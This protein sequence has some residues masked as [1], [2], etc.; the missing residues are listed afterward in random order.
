MKQATYLQ[1][2][3]AENGDKEAVSITPDPQGKV[4]IQNGYTTPYSNDPSAGGLYIDRPTFNWIINYFTKELLAI[5]LNG[6]N[7]V[8]QTILSTNGYPKGSRCVVWINIQTLQLD[9]NGST[10]SMCITVPVVSLIDNNKTNP[11]DQGALLG[12]WWLD[13]GALIGEVKSMQVNLSNAPAGYIDLAPNDA[14]PDYVKQNYPRIQTIL[15]DSATSTWGYFKSTS[16]TNFTILNPRGR[17][18]RVYSNGSTIDNGRVFTDFQGDAIRN[19]TGGWD[20]EVYNGGTPGN[21][22]TRYSWRD[23]AHLAG[24]NFTQDY[25]G[26]F[27]KGNKKTNV[28]LYPNSVSYR[29]CYGWQLD[30]SLVVPTTDPSTGENRPYNFNQKLY[31]KV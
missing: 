25:W 8:N 4:S 26:S 30:A 22:T 23:D 24:G 5:Q 12:N 1:F 6:I 21:V 10:N 9:P 18:P 14:N 7:E 29:E 31:I 11:Y 27:K 15:G 2:A 16:A 28:D 3:F 13:D 17:F 19:I 20:G